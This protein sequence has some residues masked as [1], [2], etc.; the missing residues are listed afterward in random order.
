MVWDF[1]IFITSIMIIIINIIQ[2]ILSILLHLHSNIFFTAEKTLP[3]PNYLICHFLWSLIPHPSWYRSDIRCQTS[4]TPGKSSPSPTA[5]RYVPH[6]MVWYDMVWCGQV[7]LLSLQTTWTPPS[8]HESYRFRPHWTCIEI[9]HGPGYARTWENGEPSQVIWI[10]SSALYKFANCVV[11]CLV[12]VV[13]HNLC[14]AFSW[15][16][17]SE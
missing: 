2:M 9:Q 1:A 11:L 3:C 14:L 12:R 13:T 10:V 4:P 8:W 15:R 5:A 17:D 16:T 6:D 7:Q